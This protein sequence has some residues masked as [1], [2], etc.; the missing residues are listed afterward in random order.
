MYT[1]C[2]ILSRQLTEE[3]TPLGGGGGGGGGGR[4]VIYPPP[5]PR[6]S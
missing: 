6:G 4:I 3:I 5:P 1:Y 2:E